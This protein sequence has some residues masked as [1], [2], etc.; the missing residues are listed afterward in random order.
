[1]PSIKL[2][3]DFIETPGLVSDWMIDYL[4]NP[5]DG[6]ENSIEFF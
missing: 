2:W 5:H 4:I 3:I 1:M 6:E